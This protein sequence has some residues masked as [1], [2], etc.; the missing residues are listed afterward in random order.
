MILKEKLSPARCCAV[1]FPTAAAA[2]PRSAIPCRTCVLR[3]YKEDAP[4]CPARPDP[5]RCPTRA[6]LAP[7][8]TFLP[9]E[10]RA[11]LPGRKVEVSFHLPYQSRAG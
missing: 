5:A 10:R 9:A 1:L 6:L 11:A 3:V 2:V 8:F 7:K 4:A